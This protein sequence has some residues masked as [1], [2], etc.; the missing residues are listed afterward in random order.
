MIWMLLSIG[1]TATASESAAMLY[2]HALA[3][4]RHGIF[5]KTEKSTVPAVKL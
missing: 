2:S 4:I 1:E 5:Q 3:T